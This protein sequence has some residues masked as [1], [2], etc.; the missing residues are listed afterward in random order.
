MKDKVDWC[1]KRK[2]KM[3]SNEPV[4][5]AFLNEKLI[6][7]QSQ[8]RKKM[9][10]LPLNPHEQQGDDDLLTRSNA[11]CHHSLKM[12]YMGIVAKPDAKHGFDG[13]ILLKQ[14]TETKK[15]S[16]TSYAKQFVNHFA[17]NSEIKSNWK[18]GFSDGNKDTTAANI[19]TYLLIWFDCQLSEDE[20]DGDIHD[21]QEGGVGTTIDDG[22]NGRQ[23]QWWWQW[24]Q[25]LVKSILTSNTQWHWISWNPI[26]SGTL[27][28][29]TSSGV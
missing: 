2:T 1:V 27:P 28:C 10:V 11:S 22:N 6:Y 18:D 3:R 29:L 19:F 14:V 20:N 13:K 4:H 17:A 15:A 23:C 5:Y 8:W 24:S 16:K 25:F 9:E 21:T 12:M 7:T 26:K